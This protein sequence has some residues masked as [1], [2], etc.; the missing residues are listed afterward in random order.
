M[1]NKSPVK[2]TAMVRKPPMKRFFEPV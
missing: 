2:S 1:K